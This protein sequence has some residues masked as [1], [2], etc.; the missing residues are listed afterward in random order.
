[1]KKALFLLLTALG[2]WLPGL[3]QQVYPNLTFEPARPKP[4]EKIRITYN[5]AS[6]PLAD[7]KELR[8]LVTAMK[9]DGSLLPLPM[10]R[11]GDAWTGELATTDSTDLLLFTFGDSA[12]HDNNQG[13]GYILYTY[14]PQG[15]PVAGAQGWLGFFYGLARTEA[16]SR[17]FQKAVGLFEEEFKEYPESK[18]ALLGYYLYVLKQA[19]PEQYLAKASAELGKLAA[20]PNLSVVQLGQLVAGYEELQQPEKAEPYKVMLRKKA[21]AGKFVQEERYKQV[22]NEQDP[23][24]KTALF[25]H[26][27][28]DF[29]TYRSINFLHLDVAQAYRKHEKFAELKKFVQE[30]DKYLDAEACNALAWNMY[31]ADQQLELAQALAATGVAK[32][33]Q[34]LAGG[35]PEAQAIQRNQGLLG[36]ILDTYGAILV[37][38]GRAEEAYPVLQESVRLLEGNTAEVN[39]RYVSVLVQTN[40]HQ[41]A[42][43]EGDKFIPQG[44]GTPKM[45]EDLR[46]AYIAVNGNEKGYDRYL[47]ALEAS[48]REKMKK[49]LALKM[50]S[51]PAP[52]FTLQDL[53]GNTISSESLKGK[54]V[55]V[56]FWATWCAPCVAS[57]PGMQQ[58]AAKYKDDPS[59]QFLFVNAWQREADKEKIVR[60]FLEKKK[61]DFTVPMDV[62]NKVIGAY[63][64]DGIPAKFVIDPQGNI[65]FKSVGFG[66]GPDALVEEL[67]I[68]I[69]LAAGK[70]Q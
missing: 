34:A 65:R 56:D 2:G 18:D 62:D 8:G 16:V 45:K 41:E 20:S 14:N 55:V 23:M 39:E 6:T 19:Q 27:K 50:I 66:G 13:K 36:M 32:A 64:V 52:S 5:P 29:P 33:R 15:K 63:K 9:S 26:F 24:R 53:N 49:E 43:T 7:A 46:K 25:N 60:A 61:Y 11:E 22:Y 69:D 30:N 68:M 44:K 12:K 35:Q 38:R 70:G 3:A 47:A 58:T 48:A 28:K 67:S 54:T 17:D 10:K 31:E 51:E 21:P 42:M 40:R 57:M 37:K 4:G 1:M 59:V